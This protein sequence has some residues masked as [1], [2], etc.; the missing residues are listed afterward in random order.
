MTLCTPN[1]AR[2]TSKRVWPGQD[3]HPRT[4]RSVPIPL[5]KTTSPRIPQH[6]AVPTVPSFEMASNVSIAR[7][8]RNSSSIS[9][10]A[11]SLRA[12]YLSSTALRPTIATPV[13]VQ[14]HTHSRRARSLC[15]S[16]A[17]KR[18]LSVVPSPV[19]MPLAVTALQQQ[20][21]GM[22]VHSSIKKRCEHCK[23]WLHATALPCARYGR[24]V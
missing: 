21:R 19:A 16:M 1:P 17:P 9:R 5:A 12:L 14:P 3:F 15:S 11:S 7:C 20:I 4:S 18:A 23:V 10:L 24:M 2:P 8:L 22:K 6:W 13:P